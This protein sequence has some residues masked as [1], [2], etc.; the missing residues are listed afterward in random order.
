MPHA[1]SQLE[2]AGIDVTDYL[3]QMLTERGY[4]F[5]QGHREISRDIKEKLAYVKLD[6]HPT[7][8][9]S[10]ELPDGE[11]ITIGDE[12]FRAPEALFQPHLLCSK[13]GHIP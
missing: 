13:D 2:L 6:F 4:N 3:A 5:S 8:E 12:L 10:Y 11:G 7:P 1:T 9:K